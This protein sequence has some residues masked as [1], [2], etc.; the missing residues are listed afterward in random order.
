LVAGSIAA[1]A[2]PQAGSTSPA[3]SWEG[4]PLPV[5]RGFWHCLGHRY[6][7]A[8]ADFTEAIREFSAIFDLACIRSLD[9]RK[10]A[11]L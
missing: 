2:E 4:R 11:T 10:P 3:S 1:R 6:D 5:W 8:V 9:V 7:L